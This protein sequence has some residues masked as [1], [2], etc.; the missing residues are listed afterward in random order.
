MTTCGVRTRMAHAGPKAALAVIRR[1]LKLFSRIVL[2]HTQS[3]RRNSFPPL[4]SQFRNA[5]HPPNLTPPNAP[6][7][8]PPSP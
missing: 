4:H 2:I 8:V 3:A 1:W 5:Q 6:Q 7:P